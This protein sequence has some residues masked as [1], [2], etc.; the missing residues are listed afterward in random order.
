MILC[1]F[2]PKMTPGSL[3][4]GSW[5]AFRRELG[6]DDFWQERKGRLWVLQASLGTVLLWAGESLCCSHW[7]QTPQSCAVCRQA[8]QLWQSWEEMGTC[9]VHV[10]LGPEDTSGAQRSLKPPQ[11]GS[12][13]AQPQSTIYSLLELYFFFF[14]NCFVP[15]A[16]R[17]RCW[18]EQS[19]GP[20]SP[21]CGIVTAKMCLGPLSLV[22]VGLSLVSRGTLWSCVRVTAPQ[23]CAPGAAPGFMAPGYVTVP[24]LPCH[25]FGCYGAVK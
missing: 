21:G 16:V 6:C 25:S 12:V 14:P 1:C 11:C 15:L 22:P 20:S 5:D 17:T 8:V 24:F 13:Q 18:G 2:S 3:E 19:L 23:R 7:I 9:L 4:A 10:W